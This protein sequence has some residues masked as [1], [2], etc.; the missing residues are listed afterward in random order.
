[1]KVVLDSTFS[2]IQTSN[3][4]IPFDPSVTVDTTTNFASNDKG[5]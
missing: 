4:K 2:E 5:S 3:Y 1:V